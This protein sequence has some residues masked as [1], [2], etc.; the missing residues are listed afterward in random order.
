MEPSS[1][2]TEDPAA[3]FEANSD[4]LQYVTIRPAFEHD[5]PALNES[6]AKVRVRNGFRQ[7]PAHE[8]RRHF[9]KRG[10]KR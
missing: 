2:T 9:K 7:P 6:D 10:R 3:F 1:L 5:L 8:K 4:P